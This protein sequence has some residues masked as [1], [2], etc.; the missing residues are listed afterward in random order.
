MFWSNPFYHTKEEKEHPCACCR[1]NSRSNCRVLFFLVGVTALTLLLKPAKSPILISPEQIEI[2]SS[3]PSITQCEP[4]TVQSSEPSKTQS[5]PCIVQSSDQPPIQTTAKTEESICTLPVHADRDFAIDWCEED[6]KYLVDAIFRQLVH[7]GISKKTRKPLMRILREMDLNILDHYGFEL[8]HSLRSDFN[9]RRKYENEEIAAEE[10]IYERH[11]HMSGSAKTDSH[12][13][14]E[15]SNPKRKENLL[16]STFFVTQRDPNHPEAPMNV[17]MPAIQDF[18]ET[19]KPFFDKMHV[20]FF[21]D[22]KNP[23]KDTGIEFIFTEWKGISYSI[24]DYRYMLYLDYMK[25]HDWYK[26]VLIIDMKDV[27]YGRDPWIYFQESQNSI[28]IGSQ[29]EI[30]IIWM[31]RRQRMCWGNRTKQ[32]VGPEEVKETM[33]I[34]RRS[35]MKPQKKIYIMTNAGILGGSYKEI[36]SI[37]EDM[38]NI[39]ETSNQARKCNSNMVVFATVIYPRWLENKVEWGQPL[40]SPFREYLPPTPDY[41][42]FHK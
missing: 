9:L 6:K 21:I 2:E 40:H 28:F 29:P 3:E 23:P 42:I 33:S 14:T 12:E 7:I 31:K 34:L 32:K 10:L 1:S 13:Q 18:L 36:V 25:K 35:V 38:V 30:D 16:L 37:V 27:K 22:F 24:N 4:C 41:V 5:E 20:V 11:K 8:V 26:Q 17:S 15:S 19:T 39:F